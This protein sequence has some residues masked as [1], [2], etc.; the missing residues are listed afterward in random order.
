[1]DKKKFIEHI[2]ASYTFKGESIILGAAKLEEEVFSNTFIRL[3]LKTFNRH[4]LIAGATGTG[5]TKTLQ[6]LAEQLSANGVP[7]LVMDIKGDLSGIARPGEMNAKITERHDKIGLPFIPGSSPVELLSLSDEKGVRLRAT[8]TEFGPVLFSKILDLNDVQAGMVAVVFKYCDDKRIPLIDL[9]DFKKVLQYVS[10]EGQA[11]FE[12]LYGK[13][14]TVSLGT[15]LRKIVELEQQGA[16]VFFGEPSFDVQDLVNVDRDGRGVVSVL[17]LSDLQDRPKLF[18]TFM[19]QLLAEI[20]STF[21]EAG[22]V[23]KPK[24]V[25]F[26]DEAHLVFEE[27]SKALLDQIEVIVKLIRSKGVG[28]FFVTQVPTDIPDDV[29]SQLGMKIQ[30][31]LRAF[32]A[33]DRKAIQKASENY[34]MSDFYKVDELITGLGIGEAIVT[35]LNE[36]GIPTALAYTF[37]RAPQSRMDVLTESEIDNIV[38]R[39]EIL[40]HYNK[41]IDRE[42]AYEILSE[43]LERASQRQMEV[44]EEGKSMREQPRSSRKEKSVIESFIS[45]TT[46]RQIGRTVARELS[47]GL[48]GVLGIGRRR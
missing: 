31:S 18:S 11:E 29:L 40:G 44:E 17:R 34:P 37:L 20:Y 26:I 28:V 46:V 8:V 15:I 9:K 19:L 39:S 45:N 7:S 33:K 47:R 3:P 32:T 12:G 27:A 10:S 25:I 38:D 43:K 24:L 41:S 14:S 4:G 48:L 30:H 1:M 42:S 35:V 23:E 6:I 5:K 16:D 36:K 22:D 2:S 21:P 13:L